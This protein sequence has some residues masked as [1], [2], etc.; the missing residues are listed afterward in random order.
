MFDK[1]Y[2]Q[3][4]KE[5][6]QAVDAI[7]GPVMVV[8]GPGTGKTH[9]LAMRIAN[10]LRRTDTEP[11]SVLALTFTESGAYAMRKKLAKI[12][13]SEAYQVEISTFHGFCN[14]IIKEYPDEFP[15]IIGANNIAEA[16]QINLF[17][18]VIDRL[19]LQ[20]LKPFGDKY[21]YITQIVSAISELKREGLG[22]DDFERKAELRQ[23][24]YLSK[25]DLYHKKGKFA[26]CLKGK[27]FN[28]K[29]QIAR[30]LELALVYREYQIELE[31]EKLYDYGDMLMKVTKTLEKNKELLLS[32]QEKYQYIL[33]D[34]HQDTNNAQNKILELLANY[35]ENPNLFLV[36]DEKQAIYRFQGASAENFNR[37]KTLYKD[38]RVVRLKSNYRSSQTILDAS[39]TGLEA[40]TKNPEIPVTLRIF[41][42]QEEEIYSLCKEI[43]RRQ[44]VET[45]VIYRENKEAFPISRML[46][47]MGIPFCIDSDQNA[48][49]DED[50]KKLL[51][52]FKAVQ[53][54]GSAR[55]FISLLHLEFL[56]VET[57][58]I[59]EI[60]QNPLEMARSGKASPEICQIYKKISLWKKKSLTE[61]PLNVFEEIVHKSGFFQYLL[62][63]KP[64]PEKIR[65]L[66]ALYSQLKKQVSNQKNYTLDKFFQ[67]LDLLEDQ[68]ILLKS[69][70]LSSS[71]KIRLMTA[72]KSK[73]LEFDRVYIVNATDKRWAAKTRRSLL[74]VAESP[75]QL[76][77][78]D[79]NLFYVAMTRAR[80]ELIISYSGLPT[81]YLEQIDKECLQ[82]LE[83]SG[84]IDLQLEFAQTAISAPIGKEKLLLNELFLKY[85]LSATALNNYLECPWK[86]FYRNL[87]RI[88]ES[89]N[90]HLMFGTA[91]HSA[92]KDFFVRSLKGETLQEGNLLES[93]ERALKKQP[94]CGCDLSEISEKGKKVLS[95]YYK[96]YFESWKNN[97]IVCEFGVSGVVLAENVAISGMIDKV[98]IKDLANRVKVIDYKTGRPKTRNALLGKT[99]NSDGNYFRQ[100]VFY[101]LL[102]DNYKKGKYRAEEGEIDFLEP[103]EK[104]NLRKEV[105][106]LTSRDAAELKEKIIS[107]SAE[108]LNLGFW[109]KTCGDPGCQYCALRRLRL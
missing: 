90:K 2:G 55:E 27:Y 69:E 106:E 5:Q 100:L 86:Y 81:K 9:L 66:R 33:V 7:E 47:K 105:F 11:E 49:D 58:D 82:A 24:N 107:V 30:I 84:K 68:N 87:L 12:I 64:S 3:L 17:R 102:L 93:F 4:N 14:R 74:K 83:S 42:N 34:E 94:L 22:P 72:H 91:A 104:G 70:A 19:N 60:S 95:R 108:I 18:D 99:K 98:E 85:G 16:Q 57:L 35:Y 28:E 29:K 1:L 23:K 31:S 21:F 53:N 63:K 45:A 51:I 79:R 89:P 61:N 8:A 59:F 44:D 65:K 20:A 40:K 80:K 46:E 15:E 97:N 54:F 48:L 38:I 56:N 101:K 50:I 96:N 88:P 26:G 10:I 32:L 25:P 62:S 43:A 71:E 103:D 67:D 75:S 52:V 76:P 39:K 92:L 13:G 78:D 73:G 109:D 41:E 6:K 36:G 37:F 77:D